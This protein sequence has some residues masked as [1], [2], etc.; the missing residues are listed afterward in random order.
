MISRLIVGDL[1]NE[2]ATTGA[3][4]LESAIARGF[5]AHLPKEGQR[6]AITSIAQGRLWRTELTA[7]C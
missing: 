2:V 7:G 4:A 3:V 5:Q 1:R 6:G